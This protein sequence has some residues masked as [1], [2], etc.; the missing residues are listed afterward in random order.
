MEL[1]KT[2]RTMEQKLRE[3]A[4]APLEA[5]VGACAE[6]QADYPDAA[7]FEDDPALRRLLARLGLIPRTRSV[8]NLYEC[9][10]RMAEAAG[11]RVATVRRVLQLY[12]SPA[13]GIRSV[14][15]GDAPSCAE[16]PLAPD[17]K[18]YQRT[19]RIKELPADQRPRERLIAGG[20]RA[21]SDAELLAIILRSGTEEQTAI[22]LGQS[23]LAKYGTYRALAARSIAELRRVKGV[24][25]AKAAQV[26]AALE[27]GR[28]M[29]EQAAAE[30]GRRISDS[31]AVY[32]LCSPRLRDQKRETFLVLLLDARNRVVREV[33]ASVG[34]LT[35]SLAHPR[36]VFG[37]AVRDS[38]AAIICVH[39]HPTGDPTPSPRDVE[40]TAKL[41][42][43]GK[44]LGIPLLDHVILGEGRHYSFAD[45]GQLPEGKRDDG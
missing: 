39:N 44:V 35:A 38:A 18:H 33:E 19:P 1:R 4:A 43:T 13:D 37:E 8:A 15:C 45:E 23:L 29:A 11:E 42:A 32:D 30:P 6:A 12:C 41:H 25:P 20:E 34:S 14:V 9:V 10:R 26:K 31:Q 3:L 16:C 27:I 24:G 36:E 21:L 2:Y 17:C 5:L 28:R 7:A 40:I 22:G